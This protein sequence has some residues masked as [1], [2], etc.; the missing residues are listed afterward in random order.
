[1]EGVS[2]PIMILAVFTILVILA[3]LREINYRI[4]MDERQERWFQ[5]LASKGVPSGANPAKHLAKKEEDER[6]EYHK[7]TDG[8]SNAR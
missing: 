1:M 6:R 2:L 8:A 3:F 4:K 5:Y 7:P